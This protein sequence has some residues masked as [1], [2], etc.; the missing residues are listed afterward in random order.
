MSCRLW[1]EDGPK[2]AEGLRVCSIWIDPRST[3][4]V[5]KRDVGCLSESFVESA[6]YVIGEKDVG[7]CSSIFEST[8]RRTSEASLPRFSNSERV[9]ANGSELGVRPRRLFPDQ[10]P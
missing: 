6:G 8:G 5:G 7:R 4:D 3:L 10:P 2:Q 1:P 9:S